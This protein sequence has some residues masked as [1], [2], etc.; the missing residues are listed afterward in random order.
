M[1]LHESEIRIRKSVNLRLMETEHFLQLQLQI[2][3]I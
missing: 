3:S 1:K 2:K